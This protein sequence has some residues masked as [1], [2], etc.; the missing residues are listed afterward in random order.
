MRISIIAAMGRNRAIGKD[1]GLP[2]RLPADMRYFKNR[3]MG[4]HLIMGRRTWDELGAALPGRT[5][6]VV[7]RD[8]AF[9]PEGAVVVRS[10]EEGLGKAE[11]QEEVFI[12]GGAVIY[13]LALPIAHRMYLTLIDADFEADTFF[14]PF[15]EARWE[16]VARESHEPDE[17]N[18]WRYSFTTWEKK[19][20]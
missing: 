7:S 13:E 19:G 3:T 16:C 20:E 17:R 18:R 6:I 10:L 8:P 2:W 9:A 4:H 5:S 1:G 14:P 12:A 15:D 11:G